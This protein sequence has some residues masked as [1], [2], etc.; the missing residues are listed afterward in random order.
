MTDQSAAGMPN[1]EETI[2][3]IREMNERMIEKSKEAGLASLDAYEKALTNMVELQEQTAGASQLEWVNA[4]ATA[5]ARYVQDVSKA[6]TDA[7][8]KMLS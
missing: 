6:Y 4:L 7:A 1:A 8:R 5:H 3:R 2:Q